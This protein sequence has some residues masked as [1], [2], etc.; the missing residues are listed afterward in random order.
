MRGLTTS[1][2]PS[3][4]AASGAPVAV[5]LRTDVAPTTIAEL[6]AHLR[7]YVLAT[8]IPVHWQ[9]VAELPRTPSLKIDRAALKS[10][11]AND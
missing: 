7:R 10:L 2:R 9:I 8:H 3:S 6:E 4:P 1:S 5:V 11:F